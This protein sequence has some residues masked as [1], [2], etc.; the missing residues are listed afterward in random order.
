MKGGEE[1][2]EVPRDGGALLMDFSRRRVVIPF[3]KLGTN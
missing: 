2:R 3:V 1:V